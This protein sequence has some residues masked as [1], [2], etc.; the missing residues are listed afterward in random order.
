MYQAKV[1]SGPY[2]DGP[3]S[4][5]NTSHWCRLRILGCFGLDLPKRGSGLVGKKRIGADGAWAEQVNA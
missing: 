5:E 2:R 3:A 4:G 1:V